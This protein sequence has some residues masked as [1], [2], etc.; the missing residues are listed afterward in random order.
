MTANLLPENVAEFISNSALSEP[1]IAMRLGLATYTSEVFLATGKELHLVGNIYGTDRKNGVS[2]FGNGSDETVALSLLLRIGAQLTGAAASLFKTG[3]DYAAAALVRQVVEIEYLAWAFETRDADAER[4]LRSDR[5]IRENFFSPRKL[6]GASS[7]KFRSKDYG[8]HCECGG[9][10]VP[11]STLLLGENRAHG[12]VIF[13]DL[14]GHTGRIW[15][16]V[17]RWASGHEHAHFV[18]RRAP[19]MSK[20]YQEW[21]SMDALTTLPPPP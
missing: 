3:N 1:I 6:R 8:Y 12:Q 20:R 11:G 7:G 13:S 10:P 17:V 18:L 14:L 15:D 21:K 5:E 2:P 16:H 19:E 9:H 4:W